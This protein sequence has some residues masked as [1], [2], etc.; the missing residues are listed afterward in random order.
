[1][2]VFLFLFFIILIVGILL[3]IYNSYVN[4]TNKWILIILKISKPYS[5]LFNFFFNYKYL[6][7]FFSFSFS[8]F[9][10]IS[11]LFSI[12]FINFK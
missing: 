3:F 9:E 4:K 12:H 7:F 2:S 10:L 8:F 11:F 1:L 6:C 5:I